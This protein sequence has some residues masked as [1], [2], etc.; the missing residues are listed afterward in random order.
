M[1][2][3]GYRGPSEW[4]PGMDS[5]ETRPELPLALIGRLRHMEDDASPA[6]RREVRDVEAAEALQEALADPR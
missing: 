5:W 1:H 3:F 2:E 6:L 4:D